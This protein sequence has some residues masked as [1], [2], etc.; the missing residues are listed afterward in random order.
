[1]NSEVGHASADSYVSLEFANAFFENSIDNSAWPATDPLKSAALVEATRILDSQF[2]WYGDIAT[3]SAQALRWPRINAYDMDGR[4]IPSDIVPKIL[5]EAVCN[6]AYFMLQNG[7]LNQTQSDVKG[8]KVGP[9]ALTFTPNESVIGVPKY[10]AKNLQ[11]LG[12]FQGHIQGS[13][14]TANAIR[15]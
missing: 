15:S 5:K 6:L 8:V 12:A 9:I 11:S 14:Y 13:V 4:K 2:D 10:I 7:G 3:D 1:M